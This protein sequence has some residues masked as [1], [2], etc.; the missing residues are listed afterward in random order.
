MFCK[1]CGTQLSEGTAFCA[2]CGCPVHPAQQTQ[3]VQPPV[4]QPYYP[5]QPYVNDGG[6]IGW[7]FLGFFFPLVGLI[8]F[9]ILMR[10]LHTQDHAEPEV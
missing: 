1:Q 4:R 7:W 8:L 5:S 3:P 6:S 10:K 2:N 9:L